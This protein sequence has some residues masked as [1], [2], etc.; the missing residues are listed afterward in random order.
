MNQGTT[1]EEVPRGMIVTPSDVEDNVTSEGDDSTLLEARSESDQDE[2][3][4]EP[5]PALCNL[6]GQTPCVW[7][8]FG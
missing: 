7:E 2:E 4:V 8:L 6:C 5:D 3:V 1:I